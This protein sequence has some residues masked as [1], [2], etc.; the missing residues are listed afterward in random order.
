MWSSVP[1]DYQKVYNTL[2][3]AAAGGGLFRNNR[4]GFICGVITPL[5]FTDDVTVATEVA[6]WS[7]NGGGRDLRK[8]FENW[9]RESGATFVQF[10]SLADKD[11]ARVNKLM[12][13]AGFN[14]AEMSYLKELS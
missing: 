10:S 13:K 4:G 11:M 2:L 5:I 1:F 14:L 6:W 7:P 3:N 9:A 8:A 12:N